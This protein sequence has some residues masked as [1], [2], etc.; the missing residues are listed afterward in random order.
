MQIT[1]ITTNDVIYLIMPDRFSCSDAPLSS[2][3]LNREKESYWH[4]GNIRGIIDRLEYIVQLGVTAIWLTPIMENNNPIESKRYT[5]YHGYGITDYCKVDEHFGAIEDYQEL[6]EKAHKLGLKIV[7]D[8]VLNHCGIGSSL[9]RSHPSWFNRLDSRKNPRLTNY[10]TTTILGSYVSLYDKETTVKGWFTPKMPDVDLTNPETLEYFTK[11]INWWI[12]RCHID[13]IRLDTYQYADKKGMLEWQRM[14]QDRY[15]G[16]SIIAETWVPNAAYTAE[17]QKQYS[18]SGNRLIVMDFAFQQAIE[19]AFSPSKGINQERALY[20]HFIY[21]FLYDDA[22]HT[23]AFL[24][25][26]DLARWCYYHKNVKQVKQ[27]MGILLTIPRIPQILYGTEILLKGDGRGVE[28]GNWRCDFPGGWKE[29][30]VNLFDETKRKANKQIYQF[31]TFTQRLLLWRKNSAA[32]TRGKMLQFLP[33]NGVYVY[34]RY[35]ESEKVVVFVNLSKTKQVIELERYREI[36]PKSFMGKDL[37]SE[38]KISFQS[39]NFIL[40]KD[41]V[42]IVDKL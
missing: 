14:V 17:I 33:Q 42:I 15:P 18:T 37:V 40:N 4:G 41:E 30:D 7:F 21:D 32:I 10:N 31:W 1:P 16:L 6:T 26:H 39:D 24:D 3:N 2:K 13:A 19:K 35:T 25:N 29:D 22:S 34:A 8:F 27:A 36:I 11:I 20:D 23:L 38:K 9:L 28:D 12:D 5:S